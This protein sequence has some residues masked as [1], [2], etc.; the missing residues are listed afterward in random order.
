[1]TIANHRGER[2]PRQ[3]RVIVPKPRQT[4][5]RLRTSGEIGSAI[6]TRDEVGAAAIAAAV[7]AAVVTAPVEETAKEAATPMAINVQYSFC[8]MSKGLFDVSITAKT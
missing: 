6:K 5:A 4:G 2:S 7:D 3:V 1:M 8:G